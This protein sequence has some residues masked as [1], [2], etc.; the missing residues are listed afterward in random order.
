MYNEFQISNF[1]RRF[2]MS[3]KEKKKNKVELIPRN[4]N[5]T[6]LGLFDYGFIDNKV[7]IP[8]NKFAKRHSDLIFWIPTINSILGIIIAVT[9][10]IVATQR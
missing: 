2:Y 10:I 3:K 1:K 9:A 7:I 8:M 6:T 5:T 4:I